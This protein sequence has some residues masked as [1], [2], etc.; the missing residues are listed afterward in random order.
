[1]THYSI[2]IF[3]SRGDEQKKNRVYI[4]LDEIF[5]VY[6]QLSSCSYD[7]GNEFEIITDCFL[8]LIQVDKQELN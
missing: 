2:R 8:E 1:L 3:P 6:H 7:I 5:A 4:N